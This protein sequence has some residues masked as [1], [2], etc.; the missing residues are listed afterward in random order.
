MKQEDKVEIAEGWNT[1]RYRNTYD[2]LGEVFFFAAGPFFKP[3]VFLAPAFAFNVWI[4]WLCS[5]SLES[6]T[7]Q[8]NQMDAW[9]IE[10]CL[11]DNIDW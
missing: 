6:D 1:T 9:L 8:V 4:G 10:W 5:S 11:A 2:P 3:P 7:T